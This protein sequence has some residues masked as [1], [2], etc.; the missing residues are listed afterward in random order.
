MFSLWISGN[1]WQRLDKGLNKLLILWAAAQLKCSQDKDFAFSL[2][3]ICP[4]SGGSGA[5]L[6]AGDCTYLGLSCGCISGPTHGRIQ[7]TNELLH[8]MCEMGE[9]C[10]THD[11]KL[12]TDLT[13]LMPC[14][15]VDL[16]RCFRGYFCFHY[17]VDEWPQMMGTSCKSETSELAPVYTALQPRKQPNSYSQPWEPEISHSNLML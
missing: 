12:H 2:Y 4:G 11:R 8:G 10:R 16:Y 15:L 9:T 7:I 3:S 6:F 13:V 14:S 17:Q 5:D 1:K